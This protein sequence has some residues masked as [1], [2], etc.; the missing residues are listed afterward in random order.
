MSE[1]SITPVIALGYKATDKN[2]KCKGFQFI[3]GEWHEVEGDLVECGW[4]FHFCEQPSGPWSY[5]S[6]PGTR[7][8]KVEAQDVLDVPMTPGSE[9]KRIA[10]RI[11]LVEE[12]T[13]GG[14][15]NTGN[16][17]TGNRNTGNRNTGDQNTGDQNTGN[18][19]TGNRNT[20][21]QNTGN[22]NTGYGNTGNWNTGNQNTGNWNTG[23]GNATNRS[24]GFFNT[25][26]PTVPCF[27]VDSGL[28]FDEFRSKF[29]ETIYALAHCLKQ[30]G[31][32]SFSDYS[33]L[34]GIT[35]EKLTGLHAKHKEARVKVS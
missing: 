6:A 30:D 23:Y 31:E 22:W 19:N 7:I 25:A 32:I 3:P 18:W 12:V 1:P 27:D 33:L 20:G 2:I 14:D 17:N 8:W 21:N 28:T 4:G 13:P 15:R 24:N 11:R 26:E 29:G 5:Y 35:P 10:R 34:P 16:R 9:R